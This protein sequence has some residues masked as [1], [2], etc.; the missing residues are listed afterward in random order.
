[1]PDPSIGA[2]VHLRVEVMDADGVPVEPAQTECHPAV[3]TRVRPT[4]VDLTHFHPGGGAM[5]RPEVSEGTDAW[6][7]HWPE[8]V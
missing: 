8:Q 6:T 5:G 3:I 4:N 1:M 7:W 2:M